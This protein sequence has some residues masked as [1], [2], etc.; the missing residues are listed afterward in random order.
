M[1]PCVGSFVYVR[2]Q[3][4]QITHPPINLPVNEHPPTCACLPRRPR[5]LHHSTSPPDTLH[6]YHTHTHKH[7]HTHTH[8]HAQENAPELASAGM[9]RTM[10]KLQQVKVMRRQVFERALRK[11]GSAVH[12]LPPTQRNAVLASVAAAGAQGGDDVALLS[13]Y[14]RKHAQAEQESFAY[15]RN[16]I[17]ESGVLLYLHTAAGGFVWGALESWRSGDAVRGILKHATRNSLVTSLVPIYAVG[18]IV[19]AYQYTQRQVDLPEEKFMLYA[20]VAMMVF[21]CYR[22]MPIVEAWAPYWIGG[23]VL[24]FASFFTWMLATDNDMFKS[25]KLL[26]QQDQRVALRRKEKKEQQ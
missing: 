12:A 15:M 8:T 4:S 22:L 21:P 5:A 20:G 11:V 16:T 14:D 26:E 10:H 2:P 17:V 19:T 6:L 9:M 3:P 13:E 23:H 25:D 18:A 1:Q 7:A 24:G